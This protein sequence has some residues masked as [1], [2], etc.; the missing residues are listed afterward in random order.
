MN[1]EIQD[2]IT[3][4]FLTELLLEAQ[5][6]RRQAQETVLS[7]RQALFLAEATLAKAE[8]TEKR[9][10]GAELTALYKELPK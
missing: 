4:K 8:A 7:L 3:R 9:I 1:P 2:L 5:E 6:N 10:N